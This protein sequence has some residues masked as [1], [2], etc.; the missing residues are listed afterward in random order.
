MF[1]HVVLCAYKTR[2]SSSSSSVWKQSP[3]LLPSL[4]IFDMPFSCLIMIIQKE[5]EEDDD[6]EDT[7][8]LSRYWKKIKSNSSIDSFIIQKTRGEG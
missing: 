2:R 8:I 3:H 5:D 1:L 7:T 6:D 4:V